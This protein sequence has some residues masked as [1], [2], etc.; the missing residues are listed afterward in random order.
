MYRAFKDKIFYDTPYMLHTSQFTVSPAL[1]LLCRSFWGSPVADPRQP[2]LVAGP[3]FLY[4]TTTQDTSYN[5]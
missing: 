5:M 4:T 2:N 3:V 1:L